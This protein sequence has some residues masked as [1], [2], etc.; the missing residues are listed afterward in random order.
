MDMGF[1]LHD[2]KY[3]TSHTIKLS[4]SI[5]LTSNEKIID[6]LKN[7]RGPEK[8]K[9]SIGYSG[10]SSGQLDDEIQA[11]DWIVLPAKSNLIF[12]LSES[13]KWENITK[14]YGFN[15]KDLTGFSGSA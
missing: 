7:G 12:D 8:Y 5:S 6:D 15:V 13:E 9:F 1:V 14:Q 10:W 3:K 11:G 4:K 2:N